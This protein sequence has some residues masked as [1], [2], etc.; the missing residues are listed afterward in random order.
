MPPRQDFQ[1]SKS[2]SGLP[3]VTEEQRDVI[4]KNV[5]RHGVL[6]RLFK[7]ISVTYSI[8][9]EGGFNG[10]PT[11]N[12][13]HQ[14]VGSSQHI[15]RHDHCKRKCEMAVSDMIDQELIYDCP[16]GMKCYLCNELVGGQPCMTHN[17]M[18]RLLRSFS[19]DFSTIPCVSVDHPPSG[20]SWIKPQLRDRACI[21]LS[22]V[23]P[24]TQVPMLVAP[25]L[26]KLPEGH[27][28]GVFALTEITK[29]EG[30]D[31]EMG[32]YT[33]AISP[34]NEDNDNSPSDMAIESTIELP[35]GSSVSVRRSAGGRAG[36]LRGLGGRK[37]F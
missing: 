12:G 1:R 7:S 8:N 10:R 33:G 4:L 29:I 30:A 2:R 19:V 21:I 23:R 6:Y 18:S 26:L 24:D 14:L 31:L 17:C 35:D 16:L 32:V 3:T 37:E 22:V 28:M 34:I 36:E 5:S 9:A 15:Y 20:H 11:C 27:R 13:C 25:S